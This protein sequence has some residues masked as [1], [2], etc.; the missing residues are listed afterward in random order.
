[1][2]KLKFEQKGFMRTK[3]Q[4]VMYALRTSCTLYKAQGYNVCEICYV[5]I[6]Q[7]SRRETNVIIN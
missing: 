5:Q 4:F 6:W 3:I 2:L 7:I 1:M